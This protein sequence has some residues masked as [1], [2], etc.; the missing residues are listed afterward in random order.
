M[1]LRA[2]CNKIDQFPQDG[3]KIGHQKLDENFLMGI[4][5]FAQDASFVSCTAATANDFYGLVD[6][7]TSHLKCRTHLRL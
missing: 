3:M 7:V 2:A 4:V 5:A 6:D 1:A